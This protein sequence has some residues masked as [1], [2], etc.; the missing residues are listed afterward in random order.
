MSMRFINIISGPLVGGIVGYITNYLAIKMLFFPSKPVMIGKFRLPFTPGIVPRHKNR[1]AHI[2]GDAVV[3]R[4]FNTNDLEEVFMSD[5]FKNGVADSITDL[6]YNGEASLGQLFSGLK[7]DTQDSGKLVDILKD[8]LCIRIQAGILKSDLPRLIAEEGG[9]LVKERFGGSPLGKLINEDIIAIIAVP[10][11]EQIE[12]FVINHG[13]SV[14]R[15]LLDEELNELSN[16]PVS[17][18]VRQL[19]P[20]RESLHKLISD[21]YTK[22][23]RNRVRSIV[24]TIDIKNQITEK[25]LSMEAKEIEALVLSVVKRELSYVVFFGFV[26]GVIIGTINIFI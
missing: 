3:A 17:G 10:L 9:R 25:V 13:R 19:A 6:L 4:F 15:P 12:K 20:D 16:V 11:S 22:F 1:L 21:L 8:E 18:I 2:L 7:L 26:L 5:Y 24:G 14:I 23:M